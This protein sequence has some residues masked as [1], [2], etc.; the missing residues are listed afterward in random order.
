MAAPSMMRPLG[1]SSANTVR[2]VNTMNMNPAARELTPESSSS[3]SAS[4][5]DVCRAMIRPEVYFSWNSRLSRWVCRKTRTRRSSSIAWLSLAVLV[6]Y[7]AVSHAVTTAA[8]RYPTP[9][10]TSGV[11]SP[12][13]RAGSARS[14]PKAMS[15][16]PAA[17]A[18]CEITTM[19]T[20]SQNRTRMGRISEPRR[21]RDRLRTARLSAEARR[22]ESSFDV[23]K[24]G[25]VVCAVLM[26]S[27]PCRT[28]RP[29]ARLRARCPDR[30]DPGRGLR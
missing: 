19:A 29:P 21:R 20:V 28:P 15:A 18:A 8:R 5:S 13:V 16:G 4:R 14:M 17:W 9:A 24:P 22:E 10:S 12:W 30:R 27:P 11:E 1:Q 25:V 26:R 2:A 3:R 7:S 23:P 6:T